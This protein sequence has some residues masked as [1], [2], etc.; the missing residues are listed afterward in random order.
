MWVLFG[1][2]AVFSNPLTFEYGFSWPLATA[3]R[4]VANRIAAV[5]SKTVFM[6]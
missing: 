1:V 6:T 4:S 5:I 2:P 3:D